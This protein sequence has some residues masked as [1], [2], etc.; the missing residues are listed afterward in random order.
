MPMNY[1]V[2]APVYEIIGGEQFEATVLPK[3]INY[4]QQN[5]WAGRRILDLGCGT[6]VGLDWF[7]QYGYFITAVDDSRAMLRR[8]QERTQAT[9]HSY[10]FV[11]QDIR[12]ISPELGTFDLAYAL[13]VMNELS[14]L[15]DMETVLRQVAGVVKAQGLFIF[16]LFTIAGLIA[17]N[18]P[19]IRLHHRG[20]DFLVLSQNSYDYERQIQRRHF[21]IFQRPEA[22]AN[23]WQRSETDVTL[24]TYPLQAINTILQRAGFSVTAVL[25]PAITPYD[26]AQTDTPRVIFVAKNG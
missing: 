17:R 6:G 16:D 14:G 11:Q 20:D 22:Q 3:L 26:P 15:K 9:S 1:A 13:G 2:L 5:D 18:E 24:R 19:T 8:A 23:Q 4:A 21:T 25:T 12:E 10:Q 7:A